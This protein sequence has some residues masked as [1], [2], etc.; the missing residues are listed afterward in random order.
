M[1][2]AAPVTASGGPRI[3]FAAYV[4]AA[5]LL[6]ALVVARFSSD[7][8]EGL[9]DG[10]EEDDEPVAPPDPDRAAERLRRIS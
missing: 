4:V 1:F 9:P 5:T 8:Y 2:A 3:F 6:G 7:R 10:P